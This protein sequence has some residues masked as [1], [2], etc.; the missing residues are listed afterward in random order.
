MWCYNRGWE[1]K[2]PPLVTSVRFFEFPNNTRLNSIPKQSFRR[3]KCPTTSRG[4]QS[5]GGGGVDTCSEKLKQFVIPEIIPFAEYEIGLGVQR[6][7]DLAQA[8][9]AAAALEAVLVPEQVQ[10][11]EQESFGD[12]FAAVCA[13]PGYHGRAAVQAGQR[14][15]RHCSAV[16]QHAAVRLLVLCKV[17]GEII[18]FPFFIAE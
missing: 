18:E 4:S 14:G 1:V 5:T 11:L 8:T 6:G 10:R 3:K 16:G 9:V 12:A 13:L 2:P 15:G 7:S 17:T